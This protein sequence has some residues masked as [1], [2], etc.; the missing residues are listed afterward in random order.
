[1]GPMFAMRL[2]EDSGAPVSAITRAYAIAR[3][4]TVMRELWAEIEALDNHVPAAQQYD[5]HYATARALRLA[6]YWIL[7]HRGRALAVEPAVAA[8]KPGSHSSSPRHR[9]S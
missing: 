4:S 5:M 8:L 1:M 9:G 2:A 7:A 6:T 3:E